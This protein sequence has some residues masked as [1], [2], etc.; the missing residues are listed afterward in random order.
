MAFG[1]SRNR[2]RQDAQH[3]KD[4]VRAKVR[5]HG[6]GALRTLGGVLLTAALAWG[7]WEGRAW[8]LTTPTFALE[9]VGFT[10]LA[11]ATDAELVRLSGVARGQNLWRLDVGALERAMQTHPWVRSVEMT[12]QFPRGLAVQVE[13]HAPAAFVTLGDL[14]VVDEQGEPFKRL[15]AADALDLP[16][17]TGV[18]REDWARDPDGTRARLA[19]A[20]EVARAY[21]A[22]APPR[23]DR[24]SEVRLLTDGGHAL[25]AVSGQEVV[26]GPSEPGAQLRRLFRVRAELQA[27]GLRA[28]VIRLDDRTRP[29]RV[30]V[31]LQGADPERGGPV[32]R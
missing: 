12:R 28:D 22:E 27:R 3:R 21:A 23:R 10:G 11:R 30:T 32:T 25:V 15:A 17:L 19:A 16:L 5:T 20:L 31:K 2:R 1:Q 14:Y 13:E 26:L 6:P 8:A 18:T 29:G 7:G 4:A 24:L 9:H